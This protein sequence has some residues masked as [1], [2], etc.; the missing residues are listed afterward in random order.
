VFHHIEDRHA[1]TFG[2]DASACHRRAI[3]SGLSVRLSV[4][5]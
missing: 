3:V 1:R 2:T 5:A 4:A